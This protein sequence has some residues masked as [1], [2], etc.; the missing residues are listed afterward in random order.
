MV[1]PFSGLAE[2]WGQM[3]GAWS[4]ASGEEPADIPAHIACPSDAPPV[5]PDQRDPLAAHGAMTPHAQRLGP[6]A[7]RRGQGRR[8][9]NR[10]AEGPRHLARIAGHSMRAFRRA[11]VRS[12]GACGHRISRG[13]KVCNVRKARTISRG[14]PVVSGLEQ[15]HEKFRK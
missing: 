9:A 11:V 14:E 12:A 3:F 15:F 7:H 6:G 8:R 10:R 4:P 13:S 2:A 1:G 5:R